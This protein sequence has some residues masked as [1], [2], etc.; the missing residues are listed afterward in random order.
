MNGL[1]TRKILCG[2][3]IEFVVKNGES[4]FHD[5]RRA[6]K[7]DESDSVADGVAIG[8]FERALANRNTGSGLGRAI[9]SGDE[10]VAFELQRSAGSEIFDAKFGDE[11][12]VDGE[13][14]IGADGNLAGRNLDGL[15]ALIGLS[16]ENLIAVLGD[17]VAVFIEMEAAIARV[18][19]AGFGQDGEEAGTFEGEIGVIAG[20]F[21]RAL[22]KVEMCAA[23]KSEL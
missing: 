9:R 16:G 20:G 15:D 6:L 7:I 17:E 4:L 21:K 2:D 8:S 1:D 22:R 14:A 12:A 13:R 18:A 3:A 19:N 23:E 11:R 10:R 5:L